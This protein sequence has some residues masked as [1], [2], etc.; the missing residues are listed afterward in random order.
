MVGN[1][2]LEK[3]P[4]KVGSRAQ[5]IKAGAETT[6]PHS[7]ATPYAHPLSWPGGHVAALPLAIQA[8][9]LSILLALTGANPLRQ[10]PDLQM[11]GAL[12]D[13]LRHRDG[14]SRGAGSSTRG[15]GARLNGARQNQ[16][17]AGET[18]LPRRL[19]AMLG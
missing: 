15:A 14:R 12:Q 3:R 8:A 9:H 1:H 17:A 18:K 11:P 6:H 19:A 4:I 10:G 5:G 13:Q 2:L 16:Q 7:H